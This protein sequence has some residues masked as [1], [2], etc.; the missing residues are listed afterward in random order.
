MAISAGWYFIRGRKTFVG[1]KGIREED[2]I[3]AQDG[4]LST[5]PSENGNGKEE[6]RLEVI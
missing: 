4:G 2:I 3:H 5:E 1:P 6:K